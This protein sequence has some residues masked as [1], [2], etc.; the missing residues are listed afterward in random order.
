MADPIGTPAPRTGAAGRKVTDKR[1]GQIEPEN[2]SPRYTG[3]R[4]GKMPQGNEP[5]P[6]NAK[7]R[8]TGDAQ[9]NT[10]KSNVVQPVITRAPGESRTLENPV[11]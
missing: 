1:G 7:A 11:K 6:E 2:A 10:M 9:S 8:A 4:R 3:G 5:Q